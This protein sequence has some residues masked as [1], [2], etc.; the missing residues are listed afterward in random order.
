M[1]NPYRAPSASTA[2]QTLNQESVS[3]TKLRRVAL[4]FSVFAIVVFTAIAIALTIQAVQL[5]SGDASAPPQFQGQNASMI[6]NSYIGATVA[7]SGVIANTIAIIFLRRSKLG[8]PVGFNILSIAAMIAV[9]ILFK[10]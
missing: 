2:I 6:R 9:A 4:A 8:L 10:P 3:R 5:A 1:N 7:I